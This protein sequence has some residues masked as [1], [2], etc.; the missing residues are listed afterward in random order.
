MPR[1]AEQPARVVEGRRVIYAVAMSLDGYIAGPSGEYDWIVND[2]DIDFNEMGSQFDTFLIGRKTWEM[3][4]AQGGGGGGWSGMKTV[5]FSSTLRQSD[6]PSVTIVSGDAAA[7]VRKL[8]A[9]PGK[10]MWLFGGGELFRSLLDA[11]VVDGVGVAIMPVVVG[12]GIP[13]LPPPAK[14]AKLKLTK[15]K[16][17]PKTGIVSLDYDVV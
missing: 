1:K 5:V 15:H 16:L 14:R 8:K 4:A 3:M 12:G 9:E 2:P 11:G 17:Y 6:Y 10:N 7:A 13:F